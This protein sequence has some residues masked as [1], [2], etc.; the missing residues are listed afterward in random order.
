MTVEGE[1]Y[2]I[3][4]DQAAGIVRIDWLPGAE[5]GIEEARLVDEE[6]RS[7]HRG[8]VRLLVDLRDAA[9]FDRSARELFMGLDTGYRAVALL[10]GSPATRMLA[11]FFL[12][13]KRI[14]TPVQM[15]TAESEGV[16]WLQAQT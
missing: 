1:C 13:L 2:R 4:W 5:V 12:G 16:A 8:D 14:E 7:L 3:T 15:F 6:I 10:A 9:S 11:N